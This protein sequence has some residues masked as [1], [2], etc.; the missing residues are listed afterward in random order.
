MR[1]AI[2]Q[3]PVSRPALGVYPTHASD[4]TASQFRSRRQIGTG[5]RSIIVTDPARVAT[6]RTARPIAI[7]RGRPAM[8]R[9]N[10]YLTSFLAVFLSAAALGIGATVDTPPTLMSRADYAKGKQAIEAETRVAFARCR[11]E[12]GTARDICKAEVR[13]EE[14]VKIA[15]L[16]ARYRGT[17]DSAEDARLM[18]AKVQFDVARARCGSRSGEA[19]IDCLRSARED[20]TR[21][22]EQAK[23]AST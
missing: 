22:L 23:L 17:V 19:R 21:A 5:S 8:K 9:T 15:D 14:R 20:R 11:G 12:T 1:A 4:K 16:Q 3:G 18:R 6:R 7:Q 2:A 10:V 13:G